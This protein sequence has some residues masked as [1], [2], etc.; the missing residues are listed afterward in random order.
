M[1]I[2]PFGFFQEEYSRLLECYQIPYDKRY[3]WD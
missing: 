2:S 1:G 3:V